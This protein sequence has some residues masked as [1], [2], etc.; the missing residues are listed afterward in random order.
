MIKNLNQYDI[1]LPFHETFRNTS[2]ER[3]YANCH[4]IVDLT[5]VYEIICKLYPEYK[6]TYDIIIRDGVNFF[7]CNSF[8]TSWEVFDK[9]C[10]YPL[11]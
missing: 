3:Q 2:I 5:V 8:I 9:I 4:N 6:D 1:L 10:T 11:R 7:T